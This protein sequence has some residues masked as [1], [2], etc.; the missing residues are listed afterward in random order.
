MFYREFAASIQLNYGFNFNYNTTSTPQPVLPKNKI[1]SGFTLEMPTF[2][3]KMSTSFTAMPVQHKPFSHFLAFDTRVPASSSIT[4][5]VQTTPPTILCR[6][7]KSQSTAYLNI[8]APRIVSKPL[9]RYIAEFPSTITYILNTTN[10]S[11][12]VSHEIQA[13]F[14]SLRFR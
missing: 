5:I 3:A 13:L 14:R 9:G 11:V 4:S 2:I 7:C 8:T 10:L 12:R 6:F 1:Q